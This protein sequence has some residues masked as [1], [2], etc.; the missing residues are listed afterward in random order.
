VL[1]RGKHKGVTEKRFFLTVQLYFQIY[2]YTV[3]RQQFKSIVSRDVVL[4]E[5]IDV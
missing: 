5:T 3:Y 1:S 4:T 2:L